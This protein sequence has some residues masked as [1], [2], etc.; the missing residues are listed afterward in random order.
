VTKSELHPLDACAVVN[1]PG[2]E[3][4]AETVQADA[5]GKT[6][7]LSGRHPAA[8]PEMLPLTYREA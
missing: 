7:N 8:M 5:F 4:M 1:E 2:S 3:V 6:R